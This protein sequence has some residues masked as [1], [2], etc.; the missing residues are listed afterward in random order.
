SPSGDGEMPKAL[1]RGAPTR[2]GSGTR[3]TPVCPRWG[4]VAPSLRVRPALCQIVKRI[5]AAIP[6]EGPPFARLA[7]QSKIQITD[8]DFF[9]FTRLCQDASQRIDDQRMSPKFD[10]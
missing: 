5:D 8:E 6:E 9:V 7:N 1:K 3:V 10:L 2:P 4:S